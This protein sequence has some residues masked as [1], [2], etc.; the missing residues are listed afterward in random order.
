MNTKSSAAHNKQPQKWI[1]YEYQSPLVRKVTKI[2]KHTNLHIAYRASHTLYNLLKTS[3]QKNDK[4]SA[5]G[6]CVLKC[7]VCDKIC[8]GQTGSNLKTRFLE[9]HT[10]IKTNNPKPAYTLHIVN[11]RY[12]F[13]PI[14]GTNQLI[15][16]CN[17]G[18]RMNCMENFYIQ[19]HQQGSFMD[20]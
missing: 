11:N 16:P 17:K 3:K 8:V 15:K 7:A 18:C 10:Y 13:S 12:E 2:F 20:K 19:V 5:S 4:Y 1:T 14:D 9:H 6:I